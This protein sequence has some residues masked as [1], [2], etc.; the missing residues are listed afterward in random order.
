MRL[1]WACCRV[2]ARETQPSSPLQLSYRY[3]RHH[4]PLTLSGPSTREAFYSVTFAEHTGSAAKP[5]ALA[6]GTRI[7]HTHTHGNAPGHPRAPHLPSATQPPTSRTMRRPTGPTTDATPRPRAGAM[8]DGTLRPP[9]CAP[10]R[11]RPRPSQRGLKP[12]VRRGSVCGDNGGAVRGDWGN[13]GGLHGGGGGR[14]AEGGA[15]DSG[16][17]GHRRWGRGV[18]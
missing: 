13:P 12:S 17:Q 8:L 16:A 1:A 18:G 14:V 9:T 15:P 7:A 5:G 10:E 2:N 6:W 3:H 4:L 11:G